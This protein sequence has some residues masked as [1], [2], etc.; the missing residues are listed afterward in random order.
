MKMNIIAGKIFERLFYIL[1][2][3]VVAAILEYGAQQK[4]VIAVVCTLCAA[5]VANRFTRHLE[6]DKQDSVE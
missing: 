6:K 4:L 2:G 5:I 1:G 3:M